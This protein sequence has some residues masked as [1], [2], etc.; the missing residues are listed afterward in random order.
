MKKVQLLVLA[1]G[2]LL[3]A[4]CAESST[5][6]SQMRT[7]QNGAKPAFDFTCPSGYVIGYDDDGNPVCVPAGTTSSQ[8]A[9]SRPVP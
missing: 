1:A 5:A 4:A 6:P 3:F 2:A 9:A 7:K 8:T